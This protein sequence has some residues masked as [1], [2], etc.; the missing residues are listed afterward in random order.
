KGDRGRLAVIG[1]TPGMTGAARLAAR[2]AFAGGA[3]V[4]HVV[5][6][7]QAV[8]DIALAEPDVLVSGHPFTTPLQEPLVELLYRVDAVVIGPG[9]GREPGRGEFVLAVLEHSRRALV[10]AD[11]L[12]VLAP[13]REQLAN[14]AADR[15]LLLTPHVGGFRPLVPGCAGG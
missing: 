13:H 6:P 14:L 11:A 1:G 5:V 2:S 12:T 10:D 15:E 7:D 9:L 3:G 4:V 8:S